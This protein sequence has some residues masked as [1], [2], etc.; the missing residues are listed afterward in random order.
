MI[1]ES[2]FKNVKKKIVGLFVAF[3]LITSA[4][5]GLTI[6]NNFRVSAYYEQSSSYFSDANFTSYSGRS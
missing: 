2:K 6:S 5:G 3:G 4:F 1:K